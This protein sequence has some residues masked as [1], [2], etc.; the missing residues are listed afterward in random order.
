MILLVMLFG[1]PEFGVREA[2]RSALSTRRIIT[3]VLRSMKR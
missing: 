2:K 3:T 1:V